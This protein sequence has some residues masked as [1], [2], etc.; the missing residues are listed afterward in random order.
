MTNKEIM[1]KLDEL[2]V[3]YDPKA[4]KPELE[5]L[6]NENP[7]YQKEQEDIRIEEEKKQKEKEE[8]EAEAKKKADEKE[9]K[10]AE[11]KEKKEKEEADK[12]A[13]EEKNKKPEPID[14]KTKLQRIKESL[15]KQPK[16]RILIPKEKSETEGAFTTVQINGYM[17][18]IKKGVY[19]D[20]PEQV[21][22]ILNESA[23]IKEEAQEEA[24]RQMS[25]LERP[26]FDNSN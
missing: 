2:E 9:L 7:V 18:Q 8:A 6:L 23:Q 12:K 22:D 19:V 4:K 21:A 13:E 17:L 3:D 26:E 20:V 16:V 14:Y 5:K 10:E 15:A 25:N 11:E 1:E 24:N